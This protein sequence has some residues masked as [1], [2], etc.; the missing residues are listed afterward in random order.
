[1]VTA[2]VTRS[3][4]K[5]VEA[6]EYRAMIAG[7]EVDNRIDETAGIIRDVK[8]CGLESINIAR[9]LGLGPEFG[10]ALDEPYSYDPE[11]LRAAVPLYDHCYVYVDHPRS[12]ID[13]NMRRVVSAGDREMRS[14]FGRLRNPRF[15]DG[16]G[17]RADL[18]YLRT[19]PEAASIIERAQR[20]PEQLGLSHRA[21]LTCSL[22]NGRVCVVE[23]KRIKS[24]DL[25]SGLAGTTLTLF[26]SAVMTP[27]ELADAASKP[28]EATEE[29]QVATEP[30]AEDTRT[31][32][33]LVRAGIRE[34]AM[35]IIDGDGTAAEKIKSLTPILEQFDALTGVMSGEP[36]DSPDEAKESGHSKD[37]AELAR[38]R[39]QDAA[40]AKLEKAGLAATS[41]RVKSVAAM[42][43]AADQDAL[44]KEWKRLETVEATEGYFPRS[45]GA[46]EASGAP[47]DKVDGKAFTQRLK[48]RA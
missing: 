46:G 17:I 48:S 20:M 10:E 16:D 1:M 23:V 3:G 31:P 4:I 38:Y 39:R 37:R 15:V 43:S 29:E 19:H 32:D 44:I 18:E 42:E 8:V 36:V 33:E 41:L 14:H 34:A 9:I 47:M 5:T 7:Q 2:T 6:M 21:I 27:E 26:E 12:G 25:V 22:R 30:V 40:R 35:K 24:V 45:G 13:E 28:A 11:A